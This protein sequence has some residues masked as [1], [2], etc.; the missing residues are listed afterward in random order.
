M[1]K[2]IKEQNE[3]LCIVANYLQNIIRGTGQFF[4]TKNPN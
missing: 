2:E 4:I 1:D 3:S